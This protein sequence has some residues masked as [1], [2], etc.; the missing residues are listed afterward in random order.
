MHLFPCDGR[1]AVT[2]YRLYLYLLPLPS[3]QSVGSGRPARLP[4]RCVPDGR[5][6][7]EGGAPRLLRH[8]PLYRVDAAHGRIAVLAALPG[9]VRQAV[10]KNIRTVVEKFDV[11]VVVVAVDM[12]ID[13][14]AANVIIVLVAVAVAVI[15]VVVGII[16]IVVASDLVIIIF[17]VDVL[18]F[19]VCC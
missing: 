6:G 5:S 18:I 11:V 19:L 9:K 12:V 15:V 7:A 1:L 17:I 3:R 10:K 2:E 13:V 4:E 14:V 16:I 8:E